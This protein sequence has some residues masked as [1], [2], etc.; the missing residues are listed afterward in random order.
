MRLLLTRGFLKTPLSAS[1]GPCERINQGF[2]RAQLRHLNNQHQT[3]DKMSG[4]GNELRA[5]TILASEKKPTSN[6]GTGAKRREQ[7]DNNKRQQLLLQVTGNR[8]EATGDV[9][10]R[11]VSHSLNRLVSPAKAN[12]AL[13]IRQRFLPLT[14]QRRAE[15]K[16]L[17]RT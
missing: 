10:G 4:W 14:P 1:F 3:E 7:R 15:D 2:T 13:H 12:V 9:E 8:G 6:N 11:S 16:M 5:Q 17:Y